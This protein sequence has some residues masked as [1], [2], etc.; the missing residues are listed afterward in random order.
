MILVFL[1]WNGQKFPSYVVDSRRIADLEVAP[2]R[3][4]EN[5][6]PQH[7]ARPNLHPAHADSQS[8]EL[9]AVSRNDR[10]QP[11]KASPQSFVDPAIL[12]YS[13]PQLDVGSVPTRIQPITQQTVASPVMMGDSETLNTPVTAIFQHGR[14]RD[15]TDSSAT[16]TLTKPFNA[17]SIGNGNKIGSTD[18]HQEAAA[19]G[20]PEVDPAGMAVLETIG[21]KGRRRQKKAKESPSQTGPGIIDMNDIDESHLSAK[22]PGK[23]KGW[24]QTPLIEETS[25]QKPRHI[26]NKK[27]LAEDA[28]GWATEDATDIQDMGEFDFASNLSKFDKRQVF[29]D[30]RSKDQTAE[31]DRLVSFN[32]KAKPGTNG[33]KNLHYT[34]NVLDPPEVVNQWKSEAGET[35]EEGQEEPYSSSR[36]SRRE[37]SK[38]RVGPASRKGSAI[39]NQSLPAPSMSRG[40]SSRTDSPRASLGRLGV[41]ASP[42]NGSISRASFRIDGTN[43]PCACVSPLQMLEIEQ[44]CTSELGLTEDVLAENAARGIAETA[45]QRTTHLPPTSTILVLAGNH[46]SGARAVAAARHLR[47]HTFRVSVCVLGGDREDLLLEALRR[48]LDIYK[49]G[50]GWI[51]K[52]DELQ[53]R[54]ADSTPNLVVDAVLGVHTAFEELRL[55]DQASAFEMIRWANR[56]KVPILS[57]DVP[58]GLIANTGEVTQTDSGPLV[59]FSTNVICL[60]A[61]KRGLLEAMAMK[62]DSEM[63]QVCVADIGIST[64]A[65]KKYGTRR[66]HGVEFGS[67]WVVNLRYEQA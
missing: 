4:D 45:V 32:R 44:L 47:N 40:A 65:W 15:R 60:G 11:L 64:V 14:P 2:E 18:Q 58:S 52:W 61:P 19:R 34:E 24:R 35:E 29:D 62:L 28:N 50:G 46:K 8:S 54:L 31:E 20:P 26:K 13:K 5:S 17:M 42:M 16:A 51:V 3:R 22:K 12:S 38:T 59:V 67:E 21:K 30:I 55:E 57:V 23:G 43:K 37:Q 7:D 49:R 66:R 33:G 25:P 27:S 6:A 41:T 1:L 48:Q 10:E 63:W 53:P 36:A 9:S 56:S 39:V